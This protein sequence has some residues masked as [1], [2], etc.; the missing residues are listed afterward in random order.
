MAPIAHFV[1]NT[2]LGKE[3]TIEVV[4][5]KRKKDI[6]IEEIIVPSMMI[7]P[8]LPIH[9]PSTLKLPHS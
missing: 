3:K 9:L 2:I 8:S 7:V 1:S 4:P 5:S 6:V